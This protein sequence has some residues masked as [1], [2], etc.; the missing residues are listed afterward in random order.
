MPI[1]ELA[2][3]GSFLLEL[4]TKIV[5]ISDRQNRSKLQPLI[6]NLRT[7]YF[8]PDGIRKVVECLERNERV[9]DYMLLELHRDYEKYESD[10]QT[11]VRSMQFDELFDVGILTLRDTER[12][13]EIRKEKLSLRTEIR[14]RLMPRLI[15]KKE[16]DPQYVHDLKNSI[17]SLNRSIYEVEAAIRS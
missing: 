17:E 1:A 16:I 7:I 11:S 3:V 4:R 13:E 10:V 15:N 2:S 5:S 14:D 12:L 8:A 6:N 9:T